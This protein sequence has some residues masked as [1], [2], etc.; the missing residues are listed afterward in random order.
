MR[1]Q[2][3]GFMTGYNAFALSMKQLEAKLVF[4]VSQSG[5]DRRLRNIEHTGRSAN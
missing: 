2:Q 4:C 1:E 5:A 3:F